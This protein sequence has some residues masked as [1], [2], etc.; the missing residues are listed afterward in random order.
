M[1]SEAGDQVDELLSS[2][3]DPRRR[4]RFIPIDW[5]TALPF[6]DEGPNDLCALSQHA[7]HYSLIA[8]AITCIFSAIAV[9]R[10]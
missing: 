10:L 1:R 9:M 7:A 5:D 6:R 8:S 2:D 4:Y 3:E